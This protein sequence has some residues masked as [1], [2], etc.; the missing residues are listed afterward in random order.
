MHRRVLVALAVLALVGA[1]WSQVSLHAQKGRGRGRRGVLSSAEAASASN[2]LPEDYLGPESCKD[3]HAERYQQWRSHPHSKMN[4]DAGLESVRGDFSGVRIAFQDGQ[5]VFTSEGAGRDTRWFMALER[6]GKVV[7]KYRVTRT[8]GSRFM[9]F[10]I[11]VEVEGPEDAASVARTSEQKL[12][13]GYWFKLGRWL[14]TSYFDPVGAETQ[15]DGT[16]TFD[17][18]ERPRVHL[19]SQ[20]CM[21]CHNTYP[22]VYR[23]AL[24]NGLSGWGDGLLVAAPQIQG[25]IQKTIDLA[26][27]APGQGVREKIGPQHLVV[28]GVSCESCHFGGREHVK[29]EREAAFVPTSPYLKLSP[30]AVDKGA[31]T[32][33]D[34]A[35]T[36]QHVCA[37]CHCASVTLL[38]NGA[39]TW[40]S[41]EALDE[42]G[43][44]C[45]S[46]IKCTDCH[47]PHKPG[48]PE[49]AD[50]RDAPALAACARCHE[51]LATPEGAAAHSR[52]PASA[53]VSCLECHMPRYTQ[54]L[55]ETVRTHR[56]VRPLE[57]TML[58]AGAVNACNLCHLDRSLSWTLGEVEKGWGRKIV[59]G[60][61]W[62]KN[63]PGGLDAPLG[64][65]WL[66]SALQPVR[67]L[68][69]QAYAR[70]PLGTG[71]LP[72]LVRALEDPVAVNRVFGS[73][74][75][76]RVRGR[77]IAPAEYDF[78]AL[79]DARHVQVEA[80]LGAAV[81]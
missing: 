12:P 44:A 18:Y 63:Y 20:N 33:A 10:Y 77:K 9:Q 1:A 31:K 75:V 58:A 54:G 26:G 37:Q 81:K 62:A 35:Y 78:M 59:P 39:G 24:P 66:R 41:R 46:R 56:I 7:R 45:A 13:F 8:V 29:N 32:T 48:G 69:T 17:P 65:A 21:L 52:H 3:C 64:K 11:G 43:G 60:A 74:A 51:K 27:S 55:E 30:E 25:E 38:P 34:S 76:E 5:A 47:D 6:Q 14:P 70:S 50:S 53:K 28:N 80:M 40:N 23:L 19:W 4:R 2:I 67:L 36:V 71:A 79:P 57:E 72:D 42:M 15:K 16:P 73:F 68:T 49:A 61:E 22:Y